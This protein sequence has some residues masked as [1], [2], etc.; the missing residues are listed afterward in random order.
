MHFSRELETFLE[1]FLIETA[2]KVLLKLIGR[3]C[4]R[5]MDFHQKCMVREKFPQKRFFAIVASAACVMAR[6]DHKKVSAGKF[7]LNSTQCN[8]SLMCSGRSEKF[9]QKHF[10][11]P[12]CNSM[13]GGTISA[14]ITTRTHIES[15][16]R[17]HGRAGSERFFLR[18]IN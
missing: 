13:R 8:W 15:T 1:T 7:L 12:N 17:G 2:K 6:P 5:G 18:M 10:F 16:Q 4:V 3:K 11:E 14:A 9:P